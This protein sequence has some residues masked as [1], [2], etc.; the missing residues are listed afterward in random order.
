MTIKELGESARKLTKA[1][2][3]TSAYTLHSLQVAGPASSQGH[4]EAAFALRN[5]AR[6]ITAKIGA[7]AR[8]TGSY[9]AAA[10]ERVQCIVDKANELQATILTATPEELEAVSLSNDDTDSI[11]GDAWRAVRDTRETIRQWC[12]D[13]P[14]AAT[15]EA[16][17][18]AVL[19]ADGSALFLP[20]LPS[21]E[22]IRALAHRSEIR[23]VEDVERFMGAFEA[24]WT[25]RAIE[26][27]EKHDAAMRDK[28][29]YHAEAMWRAAI[30]ANKE[31]S[32]E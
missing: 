20:E 25:E 12:I 9:P 11:Y 32:T 4:A 26:A 2:G 17:A 29:K 22:T 15:A 31:G 27:R 8:K 10:A 5:V 7:A 30:E 6:V 3:E 1:I 16:E 28:G 14:D 24:Q 18:D 23:G 21:E 13:G 19:V